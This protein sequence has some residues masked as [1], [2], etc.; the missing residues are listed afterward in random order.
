VDSTVAVVGPKIGLALGGGA[1]LG[2]SHIGVL[3]FLQAREIPVHM[4]S[5]TSIGAIVGAC[6]AANRLDHLEALA[7]SIRLKNMLSFSDPSF[8]RGSVLGA[9]KIDKI[10]KEHFGDLNIEDLAIPYAA[11][12]SDLYTGQRVVLD[13]GSLVTAVKASSAVP[14]MLPS[15]LWGDKLLADGGMTDPIPTK[16]AWDLG[17]D[18]VIAVD[19]QGDY[20]GRAKRMGLEQGLKLKRGS[21]AKIARSS[22]FMTLTNLGQ[23]VMKHHPANVVITP[24]A[25]HIEMMD[26]T[27]AYELIDIGYAA[28][29]N[30]YPQIVEAIDGYVKT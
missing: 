17:A 26:F 15:V 5:G 12:A 13:K 19:L 23:Q 11:I 9:R 29:E 18:V 27:K 30:V 4:V 25:G 3:R 28:A 22:L 6:V 21:S 20:A 14:G 10:F 2:W 16:A 7:R 24:L 1:G 8:K